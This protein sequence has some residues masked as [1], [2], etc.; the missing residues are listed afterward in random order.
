MIEAGQFE[1]ESGDEEVVPISRHNGDVD[2]FVLEE[3]FP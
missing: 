1:E 3:A 2:S